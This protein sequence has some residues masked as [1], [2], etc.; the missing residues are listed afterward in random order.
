[1]T[2]VVSV[3]IATV[4]TLQ[5]CATFDLFPRFVSRASDRF[6]PFMDYPMYRSAHH[7]GSLIEWY[8]VLGQ[9]ADGSEVELT[10]VDIGLNFSKFRH[11]FVAAIRSTDRPRVAAFADVYRV[12]RGTRFVAMRLER[13]GLVLTREGLR[14]SPTFQVATVSLQNP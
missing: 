11:I 12:R 5:V 3:V 6:W 9:C 4:L 7:E 1:M 8:R 14:P 2:R 13:Y 10:P